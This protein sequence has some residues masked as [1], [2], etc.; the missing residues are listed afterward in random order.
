MIKGNKGFTLMEAIV[1]ASILTFIIIAMYGMVTTGRR[2][3]LI[4]ESLVG[5]QQSAR[6]AL[7]RI[8]SE[9]RNSAA[10]HVRITNTLFADAIDSIRFDIPIDADGNGFIDLVPGSSMLVY[11]VE[12]NPDWEIEFQLDAGSRQIIR[13]VL[14]QAGVE[15]SRQIVANNIRALNIQNETGGTEVPQQA[16]NISLT[17][18][19]DTIQGRTINLPIEVTLNTRVNLRN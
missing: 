12:N 17:A 7:E 5:A 8:T 16:V 10:S 18:T 15:Q 11:G 4:G 2:S 6:N 14:D 9:L 13:R 19:I 1:V 3:W